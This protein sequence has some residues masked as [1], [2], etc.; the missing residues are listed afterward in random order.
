MK[1]F[2]Q[3]GLP[4]PQNPTGGLSPLTSA[5]PPL[6]PSPGNITPMPLGDGQPVEQPK[7][8]T[9]LKTPEQVLADYDLKKS[10][11]DGMS[12]SEIVKDIWSK[13]G[14]DETGTGA[15]KWG[16]WPED[17]TQKI[18][19]NLI[20]S[21]FLATENTRYKRLPI[22]KSIVDIFPGGQEEI[23]RYISWYAAGM[24]LTKKTQQSTTA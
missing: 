8:Y 23:K 17:P 24:G 20:D 16:S 3:I 2:S 7:V 1:R 21:K 15:A 14:G 5:L 4:A 13:Y 18:S 19:Q 9:A 10:F 6:S 22:G 11:N 12:T